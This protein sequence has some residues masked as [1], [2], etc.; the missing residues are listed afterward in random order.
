MQGEF[1]ELSAYGLKVIVLQCQHRP[2][3]G[4]TLYELCD[5]LLLTLQHEQ[6]AQTLPLVAN[7]RACMYIMNSACLT[8]RTGLKQSKLQRTTV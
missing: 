3:L 5:V 6:G 1:P 2:T 8:A 7:K 4:H